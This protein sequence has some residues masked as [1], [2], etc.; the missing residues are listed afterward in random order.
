MDLIV[1]MLIGHRTLLELLLPGNTPGELL[2]AVLIGTAGALLA[3]FVGERGKWFEDGDPQSFVAA[4]AGAI[5][6]LL[7]YGAVGRQKNERK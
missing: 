6:V 7:I 4:A 1:T 5:I 2:L 3:R